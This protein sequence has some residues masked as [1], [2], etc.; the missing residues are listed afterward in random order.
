MYTYVYDV[1]FAVSPSYRSSVSE[2][3]EFEGYI[4]STSGNSSLDEDDTFKIKLTKQKFTNID[5]INKTI[6]SSTYMRADGLTNLV[7][8]GGELSTILAPGNNSILEVSI[9][10]EFAFYDHVSLSY[11]G[12]TVSNAVSL[13]VLSLTDQFGR[14]IEAS[15]STTRDRD[16]YIERARRIDGDID[17]SRSN[18]IIF[19]PTAQEK[20]LG[21]LF[22]KIWINTNVNRDTIIKFTATFYDS[23]NNA[24]S[25]ANYYLTVSYLNEARITIDGDTTAYLAKG[26][27][28]DIKIE[29]LLDQVV[30]SLVLD[31]VGLQGISM[32]GLG[33]P[34]IDEVRGIK[35][36]NA[37]IY[38]NLFAKT[39]EETN[40]TLYVQA[41]VSR[42]LSSS[43]QSE[44]KTTIA[45]VIIVDFKIDANNIT[46]DG[47]NDGVLN[48]WQGVPKVINIGYNLIPESYI[49]PGDE[50]S[51]RAIADIM[52]QRSIFEENGYYPLKQD[53]NSKNYYINY[54]YDKGNLNSEPLTL[55]NRLFYVEGNQR[56]PITKEI[57]NMPFEVI[58]DENDSNLI[59]FKGL[60]AHMSVECVLETYV[61]AGGHT[62]VYET[63]FTVYIDA[64]S[65]LDVPLLISNASEFKALAPVE[66]QEKKKEDYILTHDIVLDDYVPFDTS[67]IN[68]L[69]GNGHTIF[70]KSFH[71]DSEARVLNLALF[72]QVLEG[73]LL[74]NV[75]VNVIDGGDLTIDVRNLTDFNFA[76]LAIENAG[77]ITNCEVVAFYTTESAYGDGD[78]PVAPCTKEKDRS[79]I[80]IKFVKGEEEYKLTG[81]ALTSNIAGFVGTNSGSITNSRVGG[82][83][84]QP[85]PHT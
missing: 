81:S 79:G 8:T 85:M 9:N 12:T 33:T 59:S 15:T 80:M 20:L 24:L 16:Y 42:R 57:A 70:I 10:P 44:I 37:K 84:V 43:P 17:T 21:K 28:A 46:I 66:G 39:A 34:E 78:K 6:A 62:E 40:N 14:I 73:T 75:R 47:R 13:S 52:K 35:T 71:I 51:E 11:S 19:T 41:T 38:A 53:L 36:Y 32:S 26:S 1:N 58:V 25:F 48:I 83:L 64:Y 50:A 49:N 4:L 76:G 74:K 29:V 63:F 23:N 3:M 27:S 7:Y 22:F 54:K 45:T 31:G 82:L 65:D 61:S 56:T 69:D 55:A 72:N 77:V 2:D 18:M 5:I 30:D 67:L 68:S 60:R